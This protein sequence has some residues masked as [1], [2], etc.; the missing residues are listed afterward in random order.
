LAALCACFAALLAHADYDLRVL[1]PEHKIVNDPVTGAELRFL[2]THEARDTNLYFHE[3]SW[4]TDNS[5]IIFTSERPE[6]GLMGYLTAT[7][8][9]IRV[10]NAQGQSLSQATCAY[11]NNT[12]YGVAGNEVYE[13]ALSITPAAD[14]AA[15]RSRVVARERVVCSLPNREGPC[16]LNENFSG[17]YLSMGALK[18]DHMGGAGIVII[19]TQT[20]ELRDVC[21]IPEGITYHHHVQWSRTNPNLLSFAG[22]PERI[23]VVDIREGKPWAPYHQWPGEMVT[24][25]IW[26]VNDTLLF[27]GGTHPKPTE[28]AHVKVLDV[29]SGSVQ[30]VGAGAWWEGA[31]PIDIA[32]ENWWHPAGS[33]D[34]RWI[35]A[36][37]WHGD[38]GLFEGRT[39]RKRMLTLGHRTYGAGDH[40]HVGFDRLGNQVI[41]ASHMLGNPN[42]CVATIPEEWQ[43]ANK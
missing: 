26:W 37:N 40:P 23:Y 7:G 10:T 28:D 42:V 17:Q 43:Q 16:S 34:G 38:L 12:I 20:G 21:K 2:T 24:H 8:E 35:V 1:P 39:T 11:R 5:V 6:G 36:D 32:K 31:Q 29:H 9:L 25:E 3:R 4:L 14:A 19:D 33:E 41:F 18:W 15:S 22:E 30:I 27:C 13:I